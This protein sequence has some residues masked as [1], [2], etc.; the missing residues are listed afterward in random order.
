[1]VY[2][3]IIKFDHQSP[4]III[5][6]HL[7][8][9]LYISMFYFNSLALHCRLWSWPPKRSSW[10]RPTDGNR[11]RVVLRS[12]KISNWNERIIQLYSLQLWENVYKVYSFGMHK[13]YNNPASFL[14]L[15]HFFQ[16]PFSFPMK[17]LSFGSQ[18]IH[19]RSEAKSCSCEPRSHFASNVN[20]WEAQNT[21]D[22]HAFSVWISLDWVC[23]PLTKA[24]CW[25]LPENQIE[26]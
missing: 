20:S 24:S 10:R 17:F 25:E 21:W 7:K 22:S 8:N 2:C 11:L 1:M 26:T 6:H 4:L 19:Q 13:S 14:I 9:H 5:N 12:S 23:K 16:K 18:R 3:S 15:H